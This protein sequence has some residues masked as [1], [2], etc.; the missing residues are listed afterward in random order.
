LVFMFFLIVNVGLV[1]VFFKIQRK[2]L[3]PLEI[4]LY[5]CLS[6]TLVQVYSAIQTMNFKSSMIPDQLSPEFA[7]LLN[8]TVLFPILALLFLHTYNASKGAG[9]KLVCLVGFSMLIYGFEYLSSVLG[10]FVHIT[11]KEWW[12]AAFSLL[13]NL[14]LVGIMRIFRKKFQSGGAH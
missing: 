8:R 10:V 11:L 5:W 2:Q 7:H 4:L 9:T 14:I 12:S 6:S 13:L 1:Y 3:V